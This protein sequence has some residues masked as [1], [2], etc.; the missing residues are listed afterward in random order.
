[1]ARFRETAGYALTAVWDYK[2]NGNLPS[3]FHPTQF[4]TAKLSPRVLIGHTW[5]VEALAQLVR[6]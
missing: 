3:Q 6:H 5:I 2:L 4:A 1:M